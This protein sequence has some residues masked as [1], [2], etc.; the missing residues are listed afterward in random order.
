MKTFEQCCDDI[1]KESGHYKNMIECADDGAWYFDM[2]KESAILY[3]REKSINLLRKLAFRLHMTKEEFE[4][5][6][7]TIDDL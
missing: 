7:T 6:I 3:A 1:A 2:Q 5:W 4:G